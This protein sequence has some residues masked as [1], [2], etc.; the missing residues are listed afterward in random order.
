[1]LF[2][3]NWFKKIKQTIN[4]ILCQRIE[5]CDRQE[6]PKLEFPE[7]YFEHLFENAADS[8]LL[9]GR[10]GFINCNQATLNLF[11]YQSK[12]EIFALHPAAISPEFQ[13]DGQLSVDKANKMIQIAAERGY[14]T[15][16]WLHQR[17]NGEDFWAEVRLTAIA[18]KPNSF[19]YCAIRDISDRKATEEALKNSLAKN[20]TIFDQASVGFVEI[21]VVSRK[22]I[23][24]NNLFCQ[25]TG[26]STEEL[27]AMDFLELT[28]PEDRESCLGL[29]NILT[30]GLSSKFYTEKRFKRQDGS[31]FWNETTAYPIEFTESSAKTI[32]AIIKDID[33]RKKLEQRQKQLISVFEATTDFVGTCSAD[34]VITWQNR[35]LR[36]L[37]PTLNYEQETRYVSIM[38]PEWAAQ[39]I[40]TEGLPCAQ[41]QG[42]W[43]GE[44]VI[45]DDVGTEI[46]V[47]QVIIAHKNAQGEVENYSTIMRDISQQKLAEDR[48]K[49]SEQRYSSLA[50][51]APVGIFRTDAEGNCVYVNERYCQITGLDFA[52]ALGQGWSKRL[53]EDDREHIVS[54]WYQSVAE[55]RPFRLEYRFRRSD[56]SVR[57]VFGQSVAERNAAGE[58]VGFV[59]TVTDISDRKKAEAALQLSEARA[60]ASFEQAAVGIVETDMQTGCFIRVNNHF[61]DMTG[62]SCSEVLELG[63]KELTYPEDFD[64]SKKY[65]HKLYGGEIESFTIEKRYLRKDGSV[66]WSVTTVSLI[67]V[68]GEQAERCLAIIKDITESKEAEFALKE[69]QDRF[70][71]M[72]ENVP[73]MIY[74]WAIRA[75]GSREFIYVSSKVRD[76]F[77][78][79]PEVVRENEALIWQRIHPDDL[80]DLDADI[81]E[82][83]TSLNSFTSEFRLVLSQQDIRWVQINSRPEKLENG[84]VI[85]DGVL[86]DISDRKKAEA[87]LIAKQNHLE[88]LLNNIPHLAWLKDAE[89]RFIAVNQAF[90]EAAGFSADGI[91]GQTDYHIWPLPEALSY[92]SDDKTVLE[93]GKRRKVT[94]KITIKSEAQGWIETTKTPF[95]DPAGKIAG[96][97]GIAVDITDYKDTQE[98]LSQSKQLLQL[99]L[100]TI[101]Q[102]VFWKDLNSAYLGCNLSF[103]QDAGLLNPQ[104]IIGKNDFDMPWTI[105]EAEFYR[106]YDQKIM[107]SNQAELGI[108]ESQRNAEG[109][110]TWIETNK[111]PLHDQQGKVIGILGTYQDITAKKVAEQTLKQI[112]EELENRVQA[113]TSDLAK[114]NQ[115]LEFAK[116][117]LEKANR[118]EKLLNIIIK[119]IHQSLNLNQIFSITVEEL[120]QSLCCEKVTIYKFEP[121]WS[122]RFIYESASADLTRLVNLE[123]QDSYLQENQ[124]GLYK[125][126][127]I[128]V[129]SDISTAQISPCHKKILDNFGIKSYL[130]A[131]IFIQNQLW[132]LLS[133]YNHSQNLAWQP[134]EIRL[135]QQVSSQLGVA[136]KQSELLQETITA[137]ERADKA[138]KAKSEFLANMSHE[139]RTPLNGIL[140]Y[141]QIMLQASESLSDKQVKGINTIYNSGE[142]LLSLI[143]GILDHAKIEAGKLELVNKNIELSNFLNKIVDMIG[144]QAQMKQL[145]FEYTV[146]ASLPSYIFADEQRLRQTLLNLL[147]NALKFTEQGQISLQVQAKST[148]RNENSNHQNHQILCFTVQ[149]SG[150]G[151]S[152]EQLTKIF[153]PFE[154]VGNKDRQ[155]GGTGLGLNITQKLVEKMGGDLKVTSE[156]DVGSKFWFEIA[157][158]CSWKLDES[159]SI[160]KSSVVT[161][162]LGLTS[163]K[164][165]LV[166]ELESSKQSV[167]PLPQNELI[168]LQELALLGSMQ[169]IKERARHLEKLDSKYSPLASRLI[170]LAENFQDEKITDLVEFY[171][172]LE[173]D[174]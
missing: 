46:P 130:V 89:G 136:L 11:G 79:E 31:Y 42:T 121:D 113:R 158:P 157:F 27:L 45:V 155:S 53:H 162:K 83:T 70:R 25:M 97:V 29:V 164:D 118:Y 39:K 122:G 32:F 138:S 147:S 56:G 126:N 144:I 59:G 167:I 74:R 60:T 116:Q 68:P 159:V 36:E 100:D 115:D 64:E 140:G 6:N 163:L 4:S 62:Y 96:T 170:E 23:R 112:N 84:D 91:V 93:S 99:V 20:N 61:C 145:S 110:L 152:Q 119:D 151:M 76:F 16:E 55:N 1:M 13:P 3:N 95:K 146:D 172:N 37:R 142:H 101:P 173:Q 2:G 131:P 174:S 109:K 57:W 10:N 120:K 127:E 75:D 104:E 48:L 137:K 139:L 94:E 169:K 67:K 160:T 52:S 63:A 149:D 15:F 129:V 98:Q 65:I 125:E 66:F 103:A 43:S 58:I 124:G 153:D 9:W 166:E 128:L 12:A 105:Q 132:G 82:N 28:H 18:D 86:I 106:S 49:A 141:A 24:V 168:I 51:A 30:S 7:L 88:A 111:A 17:A 77:E 134:E 50:A 92:V 102:S 85:W 133:A 8:M 33:A 135:I 69:A 108:I 41:E 171:L 21:D 40:I 19:I 72:T 80:A 73:G 47:S 71:R 81:A 34:G 78:L 154:Q 156:L 87:E 35:P 123:W 117:K 143:N 26:F 161:R 165:P 5:D 107:A 38:H 22:F 90:A 14:H 148:V 150:I 114:T 44:T 54:E